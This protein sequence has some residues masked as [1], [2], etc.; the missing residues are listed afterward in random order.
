VRKLLVSANRTALAMSSVV[1]MRLTGLRALAAAKKSV[2]PCGPRA[3]QAPVSIVPGEMAL[4]RIGPSSRASERTRVSAAA[5]VIAAPSVPARQLLLVAPGGDD[6]GA[7]VAG[8][9]GYGAGDAAAPSDDQ[10]GLV[11]QRSVQ[12]SVLPVRRPAAA[13]APSRSR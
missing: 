6:G 5:L 3:S 13:R 11:F 8:G 9:E 2:L 12:G 4:T 10:H 1:P 7:G